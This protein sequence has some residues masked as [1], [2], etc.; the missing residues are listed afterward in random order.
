MAIVLQMEKE[1]KLGTSELRASGTCDVVSILARNLIA[2][3][4]EVWLEQQKVGPS[5]AAGPGSAE[6]GSPVEEMVQVFMVV[7]CY[8]C[9]T[10]Q[11]HQVGEQ[12][13]EKLGRAGLANL[14]MKC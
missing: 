10:F 9:K 14:V 13:I 8:S 2:G 12:E 3:E 5:A 6:A 11:V 7:R 4:R 1:S